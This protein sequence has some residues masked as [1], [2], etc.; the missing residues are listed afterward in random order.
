MEKSKFKAKDNVISTEMDGETVLMDVD[1]GVYYSF[2]EV[3]SLIWTRL[4][5]ATESFNELCQAILDEYEVDKATCES[6]LKVILEKMLETGVIEK[7][8][9]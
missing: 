5:K 3:G 8:E 7:Q 1:R 4:G 9:K 6:D 2:N